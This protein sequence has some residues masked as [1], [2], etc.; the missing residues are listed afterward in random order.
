M[1]NSTLYIKGVLRSFCGCLMIAAI[2]ALSITSC[3][4][5]IDSN[6]K[7]VANYTDSDVKSYGDLFNVFWSVMNQRYCDLNEQAGVSALDWEQVYNEYKPKFD[8]L[9]TFQ[10]TTDFTQEAIQADNALAKEYFQAIVDK[11]IDQHYYVKVTLPVSYSSTETVTFRSKLSE[12][13]DRLP[14]SD[15]FSHTCA[16]LAQ[17]STLFYDNQSTSFQILGG[18][19]KDQPGTFYLG[20][21]NF[22]LNVYCQH[23]YQK[24]YLPTNTNNNYH[25]DSLTIVSKAQELAS[26]E[27]REAAAQLA[28]GILAASN[29]Y[30]NSEAATLAGE[31]MA[32]YSNDGNYYGLNERVQQAYKA[33]P[34]LFKKLT[35]TNAPT[36]TVS[37]I[38]TLLKKD[39]K[40][41]PLLDE[42][43]FSKWFLQAWA[44]YLWREREFYAYWTDLTFTQKHPSVETYRRRFLEPLKRGDIQKIILDLRGNGGGYVLDTRLLT[45]YLVSKTAVYAYMRKKEDNNPYSYTPW[46][47]QQITVTSKSLGRNIPTAVLI[48]NGSASMSE[49]TTLILKSQGDHAKAIGQNSYGAQSMLTSDNTASSGGW[50]GNVTSYLYFY[51]PFS[52]T[53]DAQGNLLESV[54]IT[55]DYPIDSMTAEEQQNLRLNT[56]NAIDRT[57][58]KAKEI[59][60]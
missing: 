32:A 40:F 29:R 47:P 43:S 6:S 51:M 24:S 58:E 14:L 37:K 53:K 52:L 5:D 12:K 56:E 59:L 60:K 44:D 7:S 19:L 49:I 46:V 41:K 22:S 1:R 36:S 57:L 8:S 11:I 31:K 48:D 38:S 35:I 42:S 13:K 20:F 10:H 3:V 9:K 39:S 55:P 17:D 45:D 25:L 27:G 23:D 26:D 28:Q 54:G 4:K 16:Q 21:S 34:N 2:T 15:H 33:A 18:F 30:L 50:K